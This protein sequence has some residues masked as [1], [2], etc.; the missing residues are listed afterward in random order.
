MDLARPADQDLYL[1]QL[2]SYE[3]RDLVAMINSIVTIFFAL[4]FSLLSNL[5]LSLSRVR[6]GPIAQLTKFARYRYSRSAHDPDLAHPRDAKSLNQREYH[7]WWS[8]YDRSVSLA[9]ASNP[10]LRVRDLTLSHYVV[11]SQ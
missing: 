11:D 4:R 10:S 9:L 6:R 5:S 1:T 7:L 3:Y 8:V 2:P